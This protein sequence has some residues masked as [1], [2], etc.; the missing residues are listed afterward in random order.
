MDLTS[1]IIGGVCSTA[2]FLFIIGLFI[3]LF[4]EHN[5]EVEEIIERRRENADKMEYGNTH[6]G[7]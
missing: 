1:W 5:E 3:D 2:L 6:K 4:R 7:S